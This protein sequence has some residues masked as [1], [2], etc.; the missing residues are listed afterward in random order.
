ME[1]SDAKLK[2]KAALAKVDNYHPVF[3]LEDEF[4]QSSERSISRLCEDRCKFL[5]SLLK[6]DIGQ[7]RILDVG[8]SM[9]YI[10]L[11]FA[12]KGAFVTGIDSNPNQIEFCKTLTNYHKLGAKFW[13]SQFDRTFCSN[14]GEGEYDIA[15]LFSVLHHVV[16]KHGVDETR[17]MMSILLDAVDVLYVEL[18]QKSENVQ[19]SWK[20][21]LP[22]DDMAIFQGIGKLRI[23]K[24]GQFKALN[25]S[26][27][28][29]MYK[30]SRD[31]KTFNSVIHSPLEIRRSRV[32]GANV[33]DRKYYVSPET[34]TKA[35]V[36][37]NA[38]K[39]TWH[40]FTSEVYAYQQLRNSNHICKYLGC[41]IRGNI[42]FISIE[43]IDGPTLMD[44]IINRK[45]RSLFDSA[46]QVIE[47]LREFY[48]AGLHWNDFRTHNIL[49]SNHQ[50]Y[51][52]DFEYSS[53]INRESTLNLFL[54][55]LFDLQSA[56]SMT[57]EAG[58]FRANNNINIEP[59]PMK[60][61]DFIPELRSLADLAL[62]AKTLKGF[63]LSTLPA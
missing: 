18:A 49:V 48:R 60:S 28:R 11:F 62:K 58:I 9:G 31:E 51:A 55:F 61:D 34:F 16:L 21:A 39:D 17:A 59:P 43:R 7:I 22:D 26:V 56:K 20:E 54:W 8:C 3:G 14:I 57:H 53:A 29:P 38:R 25:G 45:V 35:F 63:L 41:E 1:S 40:K 2:V 47:I 19:F 5:E 37:D 36:F 10:S 50:L 42:G 27:I 32:S 46:Q 23:E 30:I 6:R 12:S 13:T 24:L 33:P 15:F 52:I 44:Q 4:V